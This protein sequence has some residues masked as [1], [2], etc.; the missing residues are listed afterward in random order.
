MTISTP[1]TDLAPLPAAAGPVFVL[2]T[3][4]FGDYF[5]AYNFL[6]KTGNFDKIVAQLYF[7][8]AMQHLEDQEGQ[9][10]A[11]LNGDGVP[12]YTTNCN[13]TIA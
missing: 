8:Q 10:K 5:V 12:G 4:S 9:I 3:P 7:R 1:R 2:G 13:E 6:D 11:Y